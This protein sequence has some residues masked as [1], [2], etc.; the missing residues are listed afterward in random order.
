MRAD[1]KMEKLKKLA[2]QQEHSQ[3]DIDA[4]VDALEI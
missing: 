3:E 2:A 1:R 4:L